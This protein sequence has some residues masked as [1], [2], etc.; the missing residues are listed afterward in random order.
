MKMEVK[1]VGVISAGKVF[2]IAGIVS[3]I[4]MAIISVIYIN[5][6]ISQLSNATVQQTMIQQY[7]AQGVEF[8]VSDTLSQLKTTRIYSAI[9]IPIFSAIFSFILGVL[10]AWVYNLM[11]RVWGGFKMDLTE[12]EVKKK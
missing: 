1:R 8:D 9:L 12:H 2:A 5:L 7:Q 3:G 10:I 6:I 4:I 11:A